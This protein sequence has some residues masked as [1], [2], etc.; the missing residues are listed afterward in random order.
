MSEQSRMMTPGTQDGLTIEREFDAPRELVFRAWT[1]PAH[2]AR[3]YGPNGFTTPHCDLDVRVGGR[4][5]FCMRNEQMG[6]MWSAGVY[7]VIDPPS[8][9]VFT[10]YFS[11][12]EGNKVPS[13]RYGVPED[14]PEETTVSLTFEDQGVGRTKM[15]MHHSIPAAMAGHAGEGWSQSFDRLAAVVAM[16]WEGPRAI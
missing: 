1:E 8:R 15:T 6:D 3:W 13:E 16:G 2:F 5:R 14:F 9:L 11:D 10:L 4:L 12:E 7:Q